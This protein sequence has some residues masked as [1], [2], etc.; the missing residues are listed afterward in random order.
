[1]ALDFQNV[2]VRFFRDGLDT[3]TQKK[4]VVPGKWLELQN[5][6]L[7]PD[8][9]PQ[10]RA[11]LTPLIASI[12][13]NGV[14][15]RDNQLLALT[16]ETARSI[17]VNGEAGTIPG[18]TGY[19]QVEGK[20]LVGDSVYQD[21]CDVAYLNGFACHVW[22]TRLFDGTVIDAR[23]SVIEQATGAQFISNQ[24]L[25]TT[26]GLIGLRVAAVGTAFF[27][28][29]ADAGANQLVCRVVLTTTPSTLGAEVNLVAS[30]NLRGFFLDSTAFATSVAIVYGWADGATS[31]RVA[32]LTQVAGVPSIS[33]GPTNFTTEANLPIATLSGTAIKPFPTTPGVT[34]CGVFTSSTGANP[35]SGL[36][37]GTID[38]AAVVQTAATVIDA[39]VNPT[40]GAASVTATTASAGTGLSVY[41]DQISN[42]GTARLNPLR[43]VTVT[44]VMGI[45]TAAATLLNS[46][47]YRVNAAEASG[48]QGPWIAGKAFTLGTRLFLPVAILE[49]WSTLGAN[50]ANNNQQNTLYILDGLTGVAVARFLTGFLAQ[51]VGTNAPAPTAPCSTPTLADAESFALSAP[52][53]TRLVKANSG[54]LNYS[55]TTITRFI[56]RPLVTIPPIKRQAGPVL[57]LAGGSLTQYDGKQMAESSFHL[58]PEGISCVAVGAGGTMTA[59]VHQVVAVYEWYDSTGQRHQSAPSLPVSITTVANDVVTVLCPSL[60]LVQRS[61]AAVAFYV[62]E[63]A[64][65]TFY[66]SMFTLVAGITSSATNNKAATTVAWSI[67]ESD[68]QLRQNEA[69]YTQSNLPGT[70]LAN[71]ASPPSTAVATFDNR[72]WSDVSDQPGAFRYSQ[73]VLNATGLQWNDAL[74]GMVDSTA[75]AI[76]GFEAMDEK[77]IIFCENRLYVITGSGPSSAGVNSGYSPPLDIQTDGGCVEA[78]SIL[79]MP[80]GII[81]KSAKGWR[82]LGRDLQV[83][84]IGEGVQRFNSQ[85]VTSAVLMGDDEEC[86][87]TTSEGA[88]LVYCYRG[89]GQWSYFYYGVNYTPGSTYNPLDAV[90]WPAL[91]TS[92]GYGY[93]SI[94]GGNCIHR[95]RD[96][97]FDGIGAASL[98]PIPKFMTSSWLK[99]ASIGGYQRVRWL[100]LTATCRA[101]GGAGNIIDST[102]TLGLAFDD[103][104]LDA[105]NQSH[106][107]FATPTMTTVASSAVR[108]T[109][110]VDMRHKLEVQKCKSVQITISEDGYTVAC[111]KG[112]Q[113]L[114][115][116]LGLKRGTNKLASTNTV[117]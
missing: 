83:R 77:I 109:G 45:T 86:R 33:F 90:W 102:L 17:S 48:P 11:G 8:D 116:N 2:D 71:L 97:Q 103:V 63:A 51:P 13:G 67:T 89:D 24:V 78:R 111:L 104:E 115:L 54:R 38:T 5:V 85:D 95:E 18:E 81:F 101:E 10:L 58:Y 88:Q 49:N 14:V 73:Q 42:Y 100:Y 94:D 68:A 76:V 43:W 3:R 28:T 113:A 87:F 23:V 26:T 84:D 34:V 25:R 37:G 69:L 82:L 98:V 62:T 16:G 57:Q 74:G 65:L 53:M 4:L 15:V 75:G 41:V 92:T 6:R 1:M 79:S 30:A 70:P 66:R 52:Q 105:P 50:T 108:G 9:T 12:A 72:L 27:I 20:P 46:N 112:F 114:T 110:I 47:S 40:A 19:V 56:L 44:N 32:L 36:A 106:N 7:A 117:P 22:R 64:G 96:N 21:Q 61:G 39:T 91:K 107:Y 31:T 60:Q 93:V 35:L 29:Y 55:A 99:V 59:G 80:M